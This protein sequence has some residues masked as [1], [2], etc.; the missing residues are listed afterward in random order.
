MAIDK[1]PHKRAYGTHRG[2]TRMVALVRGLYNGCFEKG[3]SAL[4]PEHFATI[5]RS[6]L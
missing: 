6:S 5:H 3:K 1:D 4:W 2:A